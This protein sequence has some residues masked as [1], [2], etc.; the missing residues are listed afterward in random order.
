MT[1]LADGI[2]EITGQEGIQS[3]HVVGGAYGSM[4]AQVF[5]HN[6]PEVV[7]RLVLTHAYPPVPS[8]VRSV[9]PALRLFRFMPMF[10]VRSTLRAQMTGRVPADPSPELS[11]IAAQIHETLDTQLTRQAAM[12]IYL[13]MVDFDR[14]NFTYTDLDRWLG[15]I[16]IILA[17]DDP[18]T[19]EQLR[20]E[21]MALYPGA[22][23][24]MLKGSIQSNALLETGEYVKVME[25]FFEG[26]G[27]LSSETVEP[28]GNADE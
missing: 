15:K 18:T 25:D 19:T 26:K 14:Q 3:A 12:N 5:I 2:V 23:L 1:G 27:D 7:T 22:I 16:L 24:H 17:E 13:R 21:L 4:V 11:L 28:I 20:N 9:N 6:H 10:V 8:R